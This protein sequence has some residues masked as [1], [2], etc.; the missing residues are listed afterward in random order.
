[1]A[2][3]HSVDHSFFD[4]VTTEAQAYWLGFLTADGAVIHYPRGR[5]IALRLQKRDQGHIEAFRTAIRGTQ[6]IFPITGKNTVGISIWSMQLAS[7]LERLGVTRAKA[8]TVQAW[9]GEPALR[10]HY[11][12]GVFDGDGYIGFERH[13]NPRWSGSWRL[14][15]CGSLPMM[16][17]F[18]EIVRDLLAGQSRVQVT[19]SA[20]AQIYRV[21]VAGNR[22][23]VALARWLYADA[24]IALERKADLARQAILAPV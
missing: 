6:P 1:M 16:E 21:R 2:L 11:W 19:R 3:R 22:N 24:S 12:R 7:A 9:E 4:V 18:A 8:F 14:E 15:L 23:A 10:R 13:P 5:S 20:S 17:R